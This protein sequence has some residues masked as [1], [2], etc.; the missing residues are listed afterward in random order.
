MGGTHSRHTT[1]E[2]RR[3][4]ALL[5]LASAAVTLTVGPAVASATRSG[6][7]TPGGVYSTLSLTAYGKGPLFP[8]G[9]GIY[10]WV[11]TATDRVSV[12]T[13]CAPRSTNLV[14]DVWAFSVPG[15]RIARHRSFAF[16]K[17][18]PVGVPS[19]SA[20]QPDALVHIT[21]R[22]TAAAMV[23]SARIAGAPCRDN[24]YRAHLLTV[25]QTSPSN[26]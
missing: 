17:R 15:L 20:H 8:A 11:N 3:V 14:T 24:H 13:W 25:T 19:S 10:V 4:R 2:R 21:G 23:G 5:M 22:F 1:V 12:Q 7:A 26:F 18:A 16:N 9:T 6:T